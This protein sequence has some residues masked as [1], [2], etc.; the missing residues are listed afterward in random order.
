MKILLRKKTALF[1]SL[2]RPHFELQYSAALRLYFGLLCNSWSRR[3]LVTG[4]SLPWQQSSALAL[5]TPRGDP[6][7]LQLPTHA[8]TT[9]PSHSHASSTTFLEV[10]ETWN[11]TDQRTMGAQQP[12]LYDAPSNNTSP[13]APFNPKAVTEA[14]RREPKPKPKH[15]GPLVDFNK[16]PDSYLILP[17]GNTNAKP[18]SPRTRKRV[19]YNRWL[20]LFLRCLQ[21]VGAIGLLVCL[22]CVRKVEEVMGWTIRIPVCSAA[23]MQSTRRSKGLSLTGIPA[24]N[25]DTA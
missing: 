10:D 19:K 23:P 3:L 9:I 16:H 7:P 5:F 20:L 6:K 2:L 12:F 13:Y 24:R 4:L 14:S 25:R 11:C 15:E 1:I 18:M 8:S 17:Y 22:I 21:L